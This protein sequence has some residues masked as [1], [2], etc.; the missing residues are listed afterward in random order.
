[1]RS[2]GQYLYYASGSNHAGEIRGFTEGGQAVGVV[3]T[4]LSEAAI[5]ELIK[6]PL[7]VFVDSGAFSEVSFPKGRPTVV[8]PISHAEWQR[9]LD[10]YDR[11]AESMGPKVM[12]IAPDMVGHQRET[13][14]R[15]KKYTRRIWR[16]LRTGAQVACV[17]QRGPLSQADFRKKVISVLGLTQDD[18]GVTW[19]LPCAKAATTLSDLRAFLTAVTP[20][21]L[22]LLGLGP[23]SPTGKK[24]IAAVNDMSP[25][26][27][28]SMDACL[29][30]GHV[31]TDRIDKTGRR[32]YEGALTTATLASQDGLHGAAYGQGVD[33]P[34]EPIPDWT[35]EVGQPSAWL[36]KA[37]INRIAKAAN[38]TK[39]EARA[40]RADPDAYLQLPM[41]EDEPDGPARYED[42]FL[43]GPLDDEWRTAWKKFTVTERKR[44][45]T[46]DFARGMNFMGDRADNPGSGKAAVAEQYERFHGCSP[47]SVSEGNIWV[48]GKL[49]LLGPGD[50]VSYGVRLKMSSKSGAYIHE[51]DEGVQIFRR[52]K[53]GESVD[54][55]FG[56]GKFPDDIWAL[57]ECLGF[58][59]GRGEEVAPEPGQTKLCWVDSLQ[60]LAV[61]D[62]TGLTYFMRGGRMKVTDWIRN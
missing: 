4:E 19:A 16:L 35:D 12:L 33:D 52:A 47:T 28:L 20:L 40:W 51:Y 8:A 57:G 26:T 38:M 21:R 18:P 42:P 13:L 3:V 60:A 6:S 55:N 41:H 27:F 36:S 17:L 15:L 32:R 59:Y 25:T 22:H 10:I 7:P 54:L 61:M 48:P 30:K 39:A 11:L 24:F 46:R 5:R 44:L 62:N 45:A 14:Q 9:R 37:A 50:D 31:G 58:T 43:T 1:M 29:I 49:H 34:M 53:R 2:T 56:P 23:S